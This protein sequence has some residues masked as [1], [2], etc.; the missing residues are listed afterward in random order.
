M[1]ARMCV[2]VC[3]YVRVCVCVRAR[4]YK[5]I[6]PALALQSYT[7]AHSCVCV[8]IM[9]VRAPLQHAVYICMYVCIHVIYIYIYIYISCICTSTT[10]C[11]Y[12]HVCMYSC[13]CDYTHRHTCIRTFMY[14]HIY[15]YMHTCIHTHIHTYIYIHTHTNIYIYIYTYTYIHIHI[16]P[17]LC[18][19]L[20]ILFH[21]HQKRGIDHD[22][23][24]RPALFPPFPACLTIFQSQMYVYACVTL[25]FC[26]GR[27]LRV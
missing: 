1:L 7:C 3:A 9:C 5:R 26:S 4:S 2:C 19:T 6:S 16:Y 10:R 25:L 21:I 20:F 24:I 15:I 13:V 12:F 17:H 27:F 14:I 8:S 23:G 18:N 11:L 22:N